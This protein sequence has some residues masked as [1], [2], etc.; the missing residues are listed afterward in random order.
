MSYL[1]AFL[2]LPSVGWSTFY[3]VGGM[4]VIA[5]SR[6]AS[7]VGYMLAISIYASMNCFC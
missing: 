5:P 1:E 7:A 6:G 2:S 3:E 4:S